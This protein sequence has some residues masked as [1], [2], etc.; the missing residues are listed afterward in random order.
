MSERM[1]LVQFPVLGSICQPEESSKSS[2]CLI[3]CLDC[4][5][6]LFVLKSLEHPEPFLMNCIFQ[7]FHDS[8]IFSPEL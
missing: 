2:L 5:Q 6:R 7:L 3:L 1:L 8:F 4:E